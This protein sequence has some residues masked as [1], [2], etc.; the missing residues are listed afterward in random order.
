M[1][2]PQ[3]RLSAS[4]PASRADTLVV[5]T[6]GLNGVTSQNA[7]FTGSFTFAIHTMTAL[8]AQGAAVTGIRMLTSTGVNLSGTFYLYSIA[9]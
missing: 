8:Y 1:P 9:H 4:L 5:E 2:S 6:F 7:L 3:C